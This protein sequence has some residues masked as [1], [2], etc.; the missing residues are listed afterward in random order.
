MVAHSTC[1]HGRVEEQ[2]ICHNNDVSP[3]STGGN[4]GQSPSSHI[5]ALC[6]AQSSGTR[7]EP[8]GSASEEQNE[9][10]AKLNPKF[11]ECQLPPLAL[12]MI[13]AMTFSK[14]EV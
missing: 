1:W 6:L 3:S 10:G 11:S 13:K 7:A 12:A 8:Q 14:P 2:C 9:P 5:P 4:E